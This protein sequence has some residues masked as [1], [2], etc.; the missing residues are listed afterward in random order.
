MSSR[1]P[2]GFYFV[3]MC[4]AAFGGCM[5]LVAALMEN[6]GSPRETLLVRALAGLL[7]CLSGVAAEA[8]W[9]ARPWAYRASLALALVYAAAVTLLTLAVEGVGGLM[10]AF[11]I[12]FF[13]AWVVV[14]IMMYVRN[15]S[16][17]L[18]GTPRPPSP[19]PPRR[20]T[21]PVP[22]GGRQQPWW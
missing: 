19:V 5:A 12:L 2:A 15:R 13:S 4:A 17:T 22:P 7:A 16:S 14:P 9:N 20:V 11:W 6:L 10:V 21:R 3:S 18:F 1:T 8:L